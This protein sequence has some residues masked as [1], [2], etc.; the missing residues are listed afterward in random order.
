MEESLNKGAP[1]A[2]T[3]FGREICVRIEK[4]A[5]LVV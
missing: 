5:V 3:I 2:A 4:M 1:Q